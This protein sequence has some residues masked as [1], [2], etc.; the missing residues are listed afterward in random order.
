MHP[1]ENMKPRKPGFRPRSEVDDLGALDQ[2]PR[3]EIETFLAM[4]HRQLHAVTDQGLAGKKR[5]FRCI[6]RVAKSIDQAHAGR[7]A[8]DQHR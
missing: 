7:V 3:F 6:L 8:P 2:S 4:L 1:T 5:G